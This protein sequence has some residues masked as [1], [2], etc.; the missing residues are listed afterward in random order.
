MWI[1]CDQH[2]F[3]NSFISFDENCG[4]LSLINVD[5]TLWREKM[6]CSAL[7]TL[8]DVVDESLTTSR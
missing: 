4:P 2:V 3:A 7:I 8:D 5:G 6:A 1:A